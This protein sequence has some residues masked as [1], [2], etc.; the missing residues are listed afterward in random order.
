KSDLAET[1]VDGTRIKPIWGLPGHAVS[2]MVVFRIVVLPFLNQ[3]KG[4]TNCCGNAHGDSTVHGSS[5]FSPHNMRIPAKLVRN[6]ASAQGRTDFIR[7]R[8]VREK[9][10]L[11]A[12]PVLGKSGLI[13]TMVMADGLLEIGENIEGLEKGEIV[14]IIPMF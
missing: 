11:L 4:L 13:R 5:G 2:A 8:L 14:S 10:E 1:V 9:N 7:V 3:I 6:V 12:V